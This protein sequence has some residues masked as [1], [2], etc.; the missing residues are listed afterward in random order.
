VLRRLL[1]CWFKQQS[2]IVRLGLLVCISCKVFKDE[3]G[4]R[5]ELIGVTF[6]TEGIK[7]LFRKN[8]SSKVVFLVRV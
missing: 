2:E 7:K 5:W 1:R 6:K 3:N 8:S 4:G